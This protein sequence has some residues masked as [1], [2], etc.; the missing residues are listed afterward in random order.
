[1]AKLQDFASW[2]IIYISY[3]LLDVLSNHP[4]ASILLLTWSVKTTL[5]E[6]VQD[7]IQELYV[8]NTNQNI[9]KKIGPDNLMSDYSILA[10]RFQLFY[11]TTLLKQGYAPP[12]LNLLS[13]LEELALLPTTILTI[14]LQHQLRFTE[15]ATQR[16]VVLSHL[17]HILIFFCLYYDNT[18]VNQVFV[19]NSLNA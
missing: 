11:Y 1:M 7:V 10:V 3:L 8:M 4:L 5:N 9:I 18:E 16:S 12:R 2:F 6:L 13:H 19:L 15:T 17:K 14:Q